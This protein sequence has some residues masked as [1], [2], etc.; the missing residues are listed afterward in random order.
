MLSV[1]NRYGTPSLGCR[2][3]AFSLPVS[4]P[5]EVTDSDHKGV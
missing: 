5:S 1:E 3:T 4:G 2:S